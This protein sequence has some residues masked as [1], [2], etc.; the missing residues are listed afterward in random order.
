MRIFGKCVCVFQSH[1]NNRFDF[2]YYVVGNVSYVRLHWLS[3]GTEHENPS[4]TERASR[5]ITHICIKSACHPRTGHS[6]R[7]FPVMYYTSTISELD[8]CT[9]TEKLFEHFAIQ[10]MELPDRQKK[11]CIEFDSHELDLYFLLKGG[12]RNRKSNHQM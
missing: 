3:S 11:T 10:L 12:I 5:Q 4:T 1:Q 6:K 8:N 2:T 7:D 9:C